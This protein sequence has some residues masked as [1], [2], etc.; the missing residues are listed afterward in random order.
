MSVK[1]CKKCNETKSIN[2]FHRHHTN[3]DSRS[4]KCK[5]CKKLENRERWL[6]NKFKLSLNE[7]DDMLQIQ[8]DKCGICGSLNNNEKSLAV[9]HDHKTNG[10]RGLLCLNCNT[11]LGSFRDSIRLLKRAIGYLEKDYYKKDN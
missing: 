9:D 8:K 11:A 2:Q 6:K 3:L 1:V 7:Y 10:I 4:G 5:Q